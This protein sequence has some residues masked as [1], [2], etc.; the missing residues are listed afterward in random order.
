MS[1]IFQHHIIS[2]AVCLSEA[3]FQGQITNSGF[4]L[5]LISSYRNSHISKCQGSCDDKPPGDRASQNG[6]TDCNVAA[7][8]LCTISPHPTSCPRSYSYKPCL[9]SLL[10]LLLL[11]LPCHYISHSSCSL[12]IHSAT[13]GR[14]SYFTPLDKTCSLSV[15][16]LSSE[17][18]NRNKTK[19]TILQELGLLGYYM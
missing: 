7:A 8:P 1:V 5:P 2:A 11:I 15:Y 18:R 3:V 6:G 19:K 17:L 16:N 13:H 10:L 9:S 14:E 12:R 4:I